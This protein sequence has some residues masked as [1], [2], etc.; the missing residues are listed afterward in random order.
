MMRFEISEG[1]GE[2]WPPLDIADDV[3]VIG[4]GAEA[5]V[6]LPA[7][8]ARA[9]H[10]RIEGQGWMLLADSRVGGMVRAAGDSG[11]VGHGM[12]IELG[13][14]RVRVSATPAGTPASLP[15]RTE[16]LARELVRSL[17]GDD[18]APALEIERG[19]H[20]GSRR[21][22]APPDSALVIG[23]G[24]DAQWVILDE[25]L[26]RAHA[27]FRRSWDGVAVVDLGSKNGTRVDGAKVGNRPV[28]LRDGQ[29]VALGNLVMRFHDPA[30]RQLRGDA[31][32]TPSTLSPVVPPAH[33]E[34]R[35]PF[36]A[37]IAFAVLTVA[38]LAAL[39]WILAT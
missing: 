15:Q 31:P 3:V 23:R 27:E 38:A 21:T 34:G 28:E 33:P 18:A 7:D 19:I 10:I 14:F 12:V 39:V 22:L 20:A 6:R 24:D 26:S 5:Q 32:S 11:S 4:S 37:F 8:A 36:I 35:A 17:L 1:G 29:A 30:E 16:S 2:P 9:A 13:S 25:D